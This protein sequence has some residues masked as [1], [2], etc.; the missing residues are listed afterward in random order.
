MNIQSTDKQYIANTY[1]RFPLTVVGGKGSVVWDDNENMYIDLATGI[2]VNTF[3]IAD[4]T[5][6]AAVT[7]QLNTLQH[8]S[9]LYYTEPCARL[10]EMLCQRT[11]MSKVF[12]S[13]SGAEAN[14][15]AIKVARKYAADKKGPEYH[16][17]ITLKNSFHGR[18]ITTLAATGQEVFGINIPWGE[19]LGSAAVEGAVETPGG[20]LG[21]EHPE[22]V[23]RTILPAFIE[24][25]RKIWGRL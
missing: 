18:T 12:F 2:A 20:F 25:K 16:T 13:N 9:N 22:K 3:G 4:D 19:I 1:A 5:W 8:M 7:A 21:A 6:A 17:I 23:E 24:G 14:E 11:G 15:C 10:A